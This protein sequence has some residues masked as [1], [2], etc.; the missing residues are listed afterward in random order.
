MISCDECNTVTDD[1]AILCP[2]CGGHQFRR[3]TTKRQRRIDMIL[4]MAMVGWFV[5]ILIR[6]QATPYWEIVVFIVAL[7]G[8]AGSIR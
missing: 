2:V 1:K 4:A 7:L 6:G 3:V 8:I 5:A